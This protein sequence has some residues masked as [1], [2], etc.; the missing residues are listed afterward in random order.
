MELVSKDVKR[1]VLRTEKYHEN[2]PGQIY[3]SFGHRPQYPQLQMSIK[4]WLCIFLS[5][6]CDMIY[7]FSISCALAV[8]G[9][10]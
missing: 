7:I 2:S 1:S 9:G 8:G 10:E 6:K 5:Y 3:V 4:F